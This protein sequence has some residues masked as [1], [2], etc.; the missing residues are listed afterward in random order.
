MSRYIAGFFFDTTLVKRVS[1]TL[2]KSI[3]E[4]E[5]FKNLDFSST[6]VSSDIYLQS[7]QYV[8]LGE[9]FFFFFYEMDA[10]MLRMF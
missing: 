7:A 5:E 6:A 9:V 10:M 8:R 3:A 4:C 2:Y 1:D